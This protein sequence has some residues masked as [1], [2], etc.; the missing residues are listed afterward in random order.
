[1]SAGIQGEARRTL[2]PG[3]FTEVTVPV[4]S[5]RA[6]LVVPQTA[7]RPTERGFVSYVVEGDVARERL[8]TLGLR[9]PDGRVEVR[10]GLRP[11]DRIVV[12]GAEALR[13]GAK[14]EVSPPAEATRRAGA[15]A[16][17]GPDAERAGG[18]RDGRGLHP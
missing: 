9:T 12:R 1:V 7:V 10:E 17:G 4:G 13:E 18:P 2:R 8:L 11:G 14:V 15:G 16:A 3:A 6:A 5:P